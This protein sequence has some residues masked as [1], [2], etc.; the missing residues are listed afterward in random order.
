M[1]SNIPYQLL[2]QGTVTKFSGGNADASS[3][4]NSI[5][6]MGIVLCVI[7]TAGIVFVNGFKLE[8]AD[9][10]SKRKDILGAI[11]HAVYGLILVL[12]LYLLIN[13]LD[14]T[15]LNN[16]LRFTPIQYSIQ[17]PATTANP[18]DSPA[19]SV[20]SGNAD[21]DAMRKRFADAGVGINKAACTEQQ[22]Q[23]SGIPSCTNVAGLPE[24]SV[25]MVLGLKSGC[26]CDVNITGGTEPGHSA[27]GPG[28]RPV[29]LR[30]DSSLGNYLRSNTQYANASKI[31]PDGWGCS[32]LYT[33]GSYR[34]CNETVAGVS[35][36]H[37][38]VY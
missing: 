3:I 4:F 6:I 5:W 37:W 25:Q 12:G 14:P 24:E 29:D 9:S 10:A 36:N 1:A 15:L 16:Q 35:Q 2:D 34:F 11:Q 17:S 19:T 28:K 32:E 8:L 22:M 7:A 27:H 18:P 33:I 23:Q 21:E 38:H 31:N 30:L 26:G 20:P 13:L